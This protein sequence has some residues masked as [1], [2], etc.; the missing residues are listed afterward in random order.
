MIRFAAAAAAFA[1]IS[2]CATQPEPCTGEWVEWKSEKV[3]RSFAGQHYGFIRDLKKLE[4][5]FDS[6]GLLAI[7]RIARIADDA[8][9]VIA[10]FQTDVVPE[11]KLA[12]EQCGSVEKL[13]PTFTKFLRTE[14]VSDNAIKWVEGLAAFVEVMQTDT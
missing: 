7:A 11:L 2:A 10:D 4:D 6:P 8:G 5:Q 3:L 14:G 1:A 12:Y 13:L 9:E